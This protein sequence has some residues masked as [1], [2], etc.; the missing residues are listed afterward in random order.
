VLQNDALLFY[1]PWAIAG[2]NGLGLALLALLSLSGADPAAKPS[3]AVMPVSPP[4]SPPRPQPLS[5]RAASCS[6]PPPTTCAS[7]PCAA[8]ALLARAGTLGR[9]LLPSTPAVGRRQAWQS[10]CTGLQ[11]CLLGV[12]FLF[13]FK[14]GAV[15]VTP[16]GARLAP[17]LTAR[18]F[19]AAAGRL[20]MLDGVG[21]TAAVLLAESA[22][23]A[24]ACVLAHCA[25]TALF[26]A[27]GIAHAA[28]GEGVGATHAVATFQEEE[29]AEAP[30]ESAASTRAAQVAAARGGTS[31]AQSSAM[32]AVT[33]RPTSWAL[34]LPATQ[35]P[36]SPPPALPWPLSPPPAPG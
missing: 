17:A 13:T 34:H 25:L 10:L 5:R 6:T 3:A 29:A 7:R 4:P 20:G 2:A 21:S 36:P 9:L 27:V 8:W 31:C 32:V 11:L 15:S 30:D 35:R 12:T 1:L 26:V 28:N 33:A 14:P 18:R 19:A 23:V 22:L 16:L 24:A